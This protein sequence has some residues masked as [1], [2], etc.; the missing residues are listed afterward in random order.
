MTIRVE[1]A[2]ESVQVSVA[3]TG[4]GLPAH[5]D[6]NIFEPFVTDRE[7]GLG[8]GLAISSSIIEAHDGRL[9]ADSAAAGGAA[10]Q[11]T[12]PAFQKEST[13]GE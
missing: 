3:D 8:L 6:L 2:E 13:D 5:E 10:F 11:F 12:L 9:R 4:P 7:D 1:P